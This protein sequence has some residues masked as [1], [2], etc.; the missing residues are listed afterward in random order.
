MIGTVN[1]VNV[2]SSGILDNEVREWNLNVLAAGG[3]ISQNTLEAA[4]NFMHVLK[5]NNIRN[6]IKIFGIIINI[7]F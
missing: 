2:A 5:I 6:P 1:T 7:H 3:Y 4:D